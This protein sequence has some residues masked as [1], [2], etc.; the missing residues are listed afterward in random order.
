P[1]SACSGR[2]LAGDSRRGARIMLRFLMIIVG[3]VCST[4]VVSE[5]TALLVLWQRG[6]ISMHHLREIKLV[7][8][9]RALDDDSDGERDQKPEFPSAQ[10]VAQTRAVKVL[11]IDKR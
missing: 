9:N 7:L 10:Q 8:T 1:G 4:V 5:T 11:N 6:M 2:D 3:C